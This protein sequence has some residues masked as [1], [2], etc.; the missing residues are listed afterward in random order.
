M[1]YATESPWGLQVCEPLASLATSA[2]TG[3][4]C[5]M[6]HRYG[7]TQMPKPD[8]AMLTRP[9]SSGCPHGAKPMTVER[10]DGQKHERM[11][12]I[13]ELTCIDIKEGVILCCLGRKR[14]LRSLTD[15]RMDILIRAHRLTGLG[16]AEGHM[17]PECRHKL[18][19]QS[20]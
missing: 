11:T 19:L 4:P 7:S 17:M 20:G 10:T 13:G 8:G 16:C 18:F 9:P 6:A 3:E 14:R 1:G 2:H 5:R 15:G 12:R